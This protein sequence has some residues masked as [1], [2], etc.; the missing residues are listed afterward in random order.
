MHR[1]Y[2]QLRDRPVLYAWT[3]PV[4]GMG[5]DELLLY[6]GPEPRDA[7]LLTLRTRPGARVLEL[8]TPRPCARRFRIPDLDS[9]DLID[10]R[11]DF[12][13]GV[14]VREWIVLRPEAI[15]DCSADPAALRPFLRREILSLERTGRQ[16]APEQLHIRSEPLLRDGKPFV[17]AFTSV[18]RFRHGLVLPRLRALCALRSSAIPARF[19][20]RLPIPA[21]L[22][23]EW[24]A[25]E[26]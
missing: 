2:P 8:R 6:A 12:R 13:G 25:A 4:T 9:A 15:A 1:C 3:H 11:I 7:R 14:T 16:Y 18:P 17:F 26:R 19:R 24:A 20:R 22:A 23:R 5:Q 21:R 10:N